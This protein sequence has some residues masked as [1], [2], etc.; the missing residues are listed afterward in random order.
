MKY[1]VLASLLL[2]TFAFI[3]SA[4][5]DGVQTATFYLDVWDVSGTFWT[6][7]TIRVEN[8]IGSGCSNPTISF[9]GKQANN[10]AVQLWTGSGTAF[11]VGSRI[12]F[13]RNASIT[14]GYDSFAA[15]AEWQSDSGTCVNSHRSSA[16]FR[17]AEV[18]ISNNNQ[19]TIVNNGGMNCIG[20]CES[21][22]H[23]N[24]TRLEMNQTR[25][26]QNDLQ[27]T[28]RTTQNDLQ[29]A[30]LEGRNHANITRQEINVT[31]ALLYCLK[32]TDPNNGCVGNNYFN[33]SS[34]NVTNITALNFFGGVYYGD[35]ANLE[36][37]SMSLTPEIA[38]TLA[39][40]GLFVVSV[41]LS[42]YR[43]TKL[44]PIFISMCVALMTGFITL[45][46][47]LLDNTLVPLLLIGVGI[48]LMNIFRIFGTAWATGERDSSIDG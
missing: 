15:I 14:T 9:Y 44:W 30:T 22:S 17:A 47:E 24:A 35:G 1:F 12:N 13:Y 33:T 43:E 45:N 3:P 26:D 37:L 31:T 10:V 39:I 40:L 32:G 21:Q 16:S 20:G 5:A 36:G 6:N 18:Y 27:N 41:W 11:T 46:A 29:N 4:T 25:T 7:V 48:L 42:Y 28:T 2:T 34:L 8:L 23:A 38:N 19:T